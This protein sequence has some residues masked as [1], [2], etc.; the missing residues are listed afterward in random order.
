MNTDTRHNKRVLSQANQ[1][2]NKRN[3][4]TVVAGYKGRVGD[5]D[6]E[7]HAGVGIILASLT[8]MA[9]WSGRGSA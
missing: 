7:P 6:I 2:I 3:T 5:D 8:E 9:V 1:N 4:F